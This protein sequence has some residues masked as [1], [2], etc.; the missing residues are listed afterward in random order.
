MARIFVMGDPQA[1]FAKVLEVLRW[2]RALAGD[3][4]APDVVLVS[5]GDHF[6]YDFRNPTGAARDGLA[7]LRWLASHDPEQVV[8]LLGN[9]DAS[10]VM[11]LAQL[12]DE[13]FEVARRLARTID[14]AERETGRAAARARA[15]YEAAFPE[16][17]PP[18][19]LG[20]DYAS[21][22]TEQRALVQEL[23]LAGRFQLAITGALPDGREALITHAGVTAR[24][25]DLLD[26][27]EAA[28]RAIAS[29]LDAQLAAAVDAVRADWQ[30]GRN[31]PLSL[32]PLHVTGSRGE[33]GGGLLYHRPSNP[34]HAGADKAW[35][36]AASRPRRFDPRTLPVGITQIVGHSGHAKCVHELG[37]W[38]A[39]SA[40]TRKHGGIR[41]L[42][43]YPAADGATVRVVYD[44][45]IAPRADEVA[46]LILIDGELRRVPATEVALLPLAR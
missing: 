31:T 38:V 16:L 40:R 2:H 5:I 12:T 7:L 29:A 28:P 32:A 3:R 10:R 20:R 37:P 36:L 15:E 14:E 25:L 33:E 39:E 44:M 1:P 17:P 18:G 30:R 24:E 22:T 43:V 8:L 34:D 23:L 35:G 9:H 6:D 11:E 46:D 13:Q 45:G 21:F 26:H 27:D 42:R 19:V 4:I 41:T